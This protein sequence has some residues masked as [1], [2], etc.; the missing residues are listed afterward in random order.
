MIHVGQGS[1]KEETVEEDQVSQDLQEEVE[2][3]AQL[4]EASHCNL[5]QEQE[6]EE[7]RR[8][9]LRLDQQEVQQREHRCPDRE[10]QVVGHTTR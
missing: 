6:Q 5:Q 1:H 9:R 3:K 2:V 7:E 8:L 4:E 10:V